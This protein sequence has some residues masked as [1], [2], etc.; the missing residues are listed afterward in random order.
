MPDQTTHRPNVLLVI[1][2]QWRAD[3]CGYAGNADVQTPH[4]DRFAGESIDCRLAMNGCPVCTPA[5]ASLLTALR[6]HAH[7]LFL[8]DA[9]LDPSLPSLG[10]H[11]ADAG[12]E[13]AWVGK[14]HVDGN[15]RGAHIPR[16]RRHGFEHWRTLECTHA[17]H[18]SVYYRDD[19]T[20]L[21]QWPGYDAVAQT[22]DMQAWLRSRHPDRPFLGVLSWGPPH[23]PYDT[24][25]AD[26][27]KCYD[28]ADLRLPPN[29][30]AQHREEAAGCLAGYYAHCTAL[31]DCLAQLLATLE[32][33]GL[34]EDTI[35]LFTSDH[36]DLIGAHGLWDKQ[37]PWDESIR[38]PF[39][40]RG[41]GLAA[42]VRSDLII[43]WI[44]LW[45]TLCGLCHLEQPQSVHGRDLSAH[46][47]D[48]TLPHENSGLYGSYQLF[49]NWPRIAQRNEVAA[50]Y[51]PREARG[52]RSER[53]TYIVDHD[54]PWLLY[55][56]AADPWQQR[57]LVAD[58]D[59][60][61]V[62]TGL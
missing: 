57:N 46:L 36:G 58:P 43:E 31:D 56:N 2:D 20:D 47:R 19:E 10:K 54:G 1:A 32:E 8:N 23:N 34:A 3:A 39:L 33:T 25:P 59:H 9:P 11:F 60:E 18:R 41:P 45:P 7:G 27:R 35:V 26:Y 16:E 38:I 55:D 28:A 30:P 50:E 14:W 44:D 52:L 4:L 24:A 62:R 40:I 5:R 21:R 42:G 17:Y 49:G 37:G 6:P 53:W 12:Y 29:V 13:T 22:A 48:G 15:G 51:R 61:E